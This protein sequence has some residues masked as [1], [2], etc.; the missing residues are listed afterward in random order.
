MASRKKG[1][2]RQQDASGDVRRAREAADG[3]REPASGSGREGGPYEPGAAG[4]ET[5]EPLAE[6]PEVRKPDVFEPEVLE[7]EP[8][9][10]AA[11][12]ARQDRDVGGDGGGPDRAEFEQAQRERDEFRDRWLRAAAEQENLRRRMMR[13]LDDARR[14]ATADLLRRFLDVQDNFERALQSMAVADTEGEVASPQQLTDLRKGIELIFQNFQA[15]MAEAGLARIEAR[16]AEFDP[17]LHEAVGHRELEGAE[18]GT[19]VD[20]LQEGYTLGELVV[21][22]SRV[23]VA[24]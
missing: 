2:D 6:E 1:R 21:R 22:P 5:V 12:A 8:L 14:F 3:E 17:R 18:S 20:V 19:V 23:L 13:E 11:A 15:I 4:S 24:P 7:P 16:G 9:D 10:P